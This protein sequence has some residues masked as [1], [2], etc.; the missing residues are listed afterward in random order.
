MQSAYKVVRAAD[1][2]VRVDSGKFS[3]LT[4]P[5]G[6]RNYLLDHIKKEAHLLTF[7]APSQPPVPG[8][9]H[10]PIPGLPTPPQVPKGATEF[11]DLGKKVLEGE[12]V[13]GRRLTIHPPALP[14]Q[15]PQPPSIG[16]LWTNTN[17]HLPVLTQ[18]EG[19]FGK[20]ICKCKNVAI[21]EPHPSLFQIPQDYTLVHPPPPPAPPSVS[22]P[23]V[24][25][26]ALP[27]TPSIPSAPIPS[28]PAM[29][30]APSIPS[31]PAAP[32]IPSIKKPW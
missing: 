24:P 32:S 25:S 6:Q 14:N 9:P 4:D 31:A 3:V 27:A 2:S 13:V 29:P 22:I 10:V 26:V 18:V 23:T 20:Q 21:P 19:P 16:E 30:S 5:S 15:P 7:T 11:H 17:L 8:L 12:E 1:G 28:A